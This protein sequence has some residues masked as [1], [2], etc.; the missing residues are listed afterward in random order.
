MLGRHLCAPYIVMRND[1]Q[2]QLQ[3]PKG[4]GSRLPKVAPEPL[5]CR[6]VFSASLVALMFGYAWSDSPGWLQEPPVRGGS[7]SCG[8]RNLTPG[9]GPQ[10]PGVVLRTSLMQCWF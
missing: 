3:A 8:S 5:M 6:A 1:F 4:G 2:K 10:S 7:Q 9:G